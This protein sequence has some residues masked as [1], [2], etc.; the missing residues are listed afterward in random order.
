MTPKK[1]FTLIELPFDKLR[2]VRERERGAFTLIEL[3]VVIA[4]IAILAALLLPAL[5]RARDSARQTVCAAQLRQIGVGNQMYVQDSDGWTVPLRP[6]VWGIDCWGDPAEKY[7][8]DRNIPG[9]WFNSD[10]CGTG[11][12]RCWMDD[13]NDYCRSKALFRCPTGYAKA[14]GASWPQSLYRLQGYGWNGVLSQYWDFPEPTKG[15]D[16]LTNIAY[17]SEKILVG[18]KSYG[19]I[20]INPCWPA[21]WNSKLHSDG[22]CY[23]M[24]DNHARWLHWSTPGLSPG[25]LAAADHYW[26]DKK[27]EFPL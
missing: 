27:P 26:S 22:G 12:W 2:A 19:Y 24:V 1:A 10:G 9:A 8:R 23:L 14:A 13:L 20:F 15:Q 5:E 18:D 21:D 7:R 3:L 16:R 25:G 6:M 17:P 4:I 11:N